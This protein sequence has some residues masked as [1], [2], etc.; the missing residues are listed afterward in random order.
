MNTRGLCDNKA[1]DQDNRVDGHCISEDWY[2]RVYIGHP[3]ASRRAVQ[4]K[5]DDCQKYKD[6]PSN[7]NGAPVRWACHQA[8][9]P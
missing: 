8:G 3:G 1:T 6:D 9:Y 4:A 2:D 5:P 7:M